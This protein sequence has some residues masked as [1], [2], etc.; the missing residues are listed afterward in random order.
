ME[1]E[2]DNGKVDGVEGHRNS[3]KKQGF[4]RKF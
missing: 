1:M 3:E 4:M 2:D